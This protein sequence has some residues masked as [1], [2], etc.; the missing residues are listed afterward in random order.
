MP[1]AA[2]YWLM[3]GAVLGFLG[4]A[5]GAFGAHGLERVFQ[6]W[7]LNP[8]EFAKR[9]Q[10]WEVAVRYQMYHALALLAVG[11]LAERKKSRWLTWAGVAFCLGVL[12][13][14]GCLYA[15][16]LTGVRVLGMIVPIGGVSLLAGWL[17]LAV[18]LTARQE[19][20]PPAITRECG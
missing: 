12:V 19:P 20:R 16:A 14:S 6:S 10:N 7:D 4:V 9:M 13:F 2:R 11:L 3:I 1:R 5:L 8:A 15:Y 17:A 18:A